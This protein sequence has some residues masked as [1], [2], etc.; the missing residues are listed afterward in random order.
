MCP[1]DIV[2]YLDPNIKQI[3]IIDDSC[4]KFSVDPSMINSWE[5]EVSKNLSF[6]QLSISSVNNSEKHVYLKI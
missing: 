5:R 2:K 3:Y 6:F 4:G 1:E